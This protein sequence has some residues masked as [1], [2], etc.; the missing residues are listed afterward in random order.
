MS[1]ELGNITNRSIRD[2]IGNRSFA[3]AGLAIDATNTENVETTAA[4]PHCVNGVFQTELAIA[5]E[6]DLSATAVISGK[7]GESLTGVVAIPALAAGDDPV[8]KVYI[9]ACK[10]D[11]VYIVEPSVD[12]AAAQDDADYPLTCPPGYA[13]FGAIKVVCSPTDV[14]GVV[15][16]VLGTT[17]LT[18][19]TGQTVTFFD[20]SVC[21]AT[22]ADL[23]TV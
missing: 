18:G 19:V 20:L 13:P 17:A 2:T 9:L 10:G 21:P 23:A 11:T 15:T 8:T 7:T 6:I 22:V 3:K 5:A 14:A 12:V 16:F 4:V 1:N